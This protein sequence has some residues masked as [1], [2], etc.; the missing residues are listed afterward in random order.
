MNDNKLALFGMIMEVV[1]FIAM[2]T[3]GLV[4]YQHIQ[5]SAQPRQP[6][7]M[8]LD[9]GMLAVAVQKHYA[10]QPELMDKRLVECVQYVKSLESEGVIVLDKR[11]VLT[12]PEESNIDVER[13]IQAIEDEHQNES[14]K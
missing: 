8:T 14:E 4:L 12:A 1:V 11:A 13:L 2:V 3:F 6:T 5:E 10:D 7:V 9:T